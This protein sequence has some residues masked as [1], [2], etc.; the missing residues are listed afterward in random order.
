MRIE[1]SDDGCDGERVVMGFMLSG[2][3]GGR[4]RCP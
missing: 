4:W 2:G 3:E 1:D